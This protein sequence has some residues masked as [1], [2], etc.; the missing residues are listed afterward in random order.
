MV[1]KKRKSMPIENMDRYLRHYAA[2]GKLEKILLSPNT[3]RFA[4]EP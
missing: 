4:R 3:Y 2:I 1:H